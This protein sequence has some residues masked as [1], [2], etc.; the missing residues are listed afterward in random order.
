M[1]MSSGSRCLGIRMSK[2]NFVNLSRNCGCSGLATLPSSG[3]LGGLAS[4]LRVLVFVHADWERLC[5]L[6]GNGGESG[7]KCEA[8]I[9]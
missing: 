9:G 6:K 1:G 5:V 3:S 4:D 8:C 2:K 7:E